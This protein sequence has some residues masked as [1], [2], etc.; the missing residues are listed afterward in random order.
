MKS[1]VLYYSRPGTFALSLDSLW[2]GI[3]FQRGN[4][5]S[6]SGFTVDGDFILAWESF[7]Y[8]WIHCGWGFNF[9]VGTFAI[10]LDSLWMGFSLLRGNLCS[11]SG[12]TVDGVFFSAWEPLFYLW[13][14]CGWGFHFC[15]GTFAYLWIHCEW[16]FH[17]CVA[18]FP[19]FLDSLLMG[20]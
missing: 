19:I 10:S 12:F 17:L 9:S 20:F 13:I 7:L 4:L 3:Q 15:V 2:M 8:F 14:H 6:I 16:G 5:S 11:I 1:Y 18:T